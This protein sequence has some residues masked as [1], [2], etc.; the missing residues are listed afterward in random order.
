MMNRE[1]FD[2]YRKTGDIEIRN[3][4]VEKYLYM[5]EVLIR[6]Y[7]NKGV[8]YDDLYQVGAMA[9]VSAV[10]RFD[11][12]K[13]YELTRNGRLKYRA[14]KKKL[15]SK[16]QPRKT[17]FTKSWAERRQLQKFLRR[18]V[19]RKKKFCR[20]WKAVRHTELIRL[21]RPLMKTEKTEK[22]PFL[23]NTWR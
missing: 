10:E 7:L 19:I 16:F 8:E 5:V 13:G 17:P 12:E 1:L 9:L 20:Q 22:M 6:K 18:L 14:A 23:K 2:Q 3:Q 21:T 11:P 15:R 4:L